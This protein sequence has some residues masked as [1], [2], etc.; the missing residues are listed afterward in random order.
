MSKS[1]QKKIVIVGGGSGGHLTP[2]V[3]VAESL[4]IAE[5]S[6]EIVHI[7]QK[8]EGLVDVTDHNAI[9]VYYSIT[10]GKF[11]RYHGERFIA[12]I[13]DVQSFLLNARDFFKFIYGTIEAWWLLGKIKPDCIFLKGGFVS[14]PVGYAARLRHIPYLTHDSDAIPGLANRL[15]AK[16]AVFN[17]TALPVRLYPYDKAK[18][19]QV[20]IPIRKEFIEVTQKIKNEAKKQLRI[21]RQDQVVF[22]VGGGLGAQRVNHALVR[23]S[24]ELLNKNPRIIIIHLTGI[25]LFNETRIMYQECLTS[26][27]FKRVLLIDFTSE[28]YKYSSAADVIVT[29]AGATNIAEFATQAKPCIIVPNP[30]L[31]GGQQLHNAKVLSDAKAALIV[32]EE[33]LDSIGEVIFDALVMTEAQRTAL[34]KALHKLAVADSA[35]KLARLLLNIAE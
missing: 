31:T 32:S 19:V 15:T 17:T 25:K 10:A 8:K 14:V 13:L 34:G 12:R 26:E 27:L 5:P 7:G 20:G 24:R 33:E 3:A 23:A 1:S 22:C 18:T 11:R 28:L 9:D 30:V 4:K 35:D 2:L 21:N 16:H 6:V 29:R